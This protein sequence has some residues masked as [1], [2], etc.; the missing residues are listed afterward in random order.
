MQQ[1]EPLAKFFNDELEAQYAA[2]PSH[3]NGGLLMGCALWGETYIERF[4]EFCFPS[5]V[6]PR[7]RAALK[8]RTRLVVFTPA[9]TVAAVCRGLAPTQE[10]GIETVVR[11]IPDAAMEVG[12]SNRYWLL[13][14][15]QSLTLE[16]SKRAGMAYHMLMPDHV[17]SAAYFENLWRMADGGAEII[18][19]CGI[20]ADIAR[21]GPELQTHRL[22]DGTLAIPD[23]TL[24]DI[25]WRALH[26]QMQAFSMMEAKVPEL[27][28]SAFYL[29]WPGK[30]KLVIHCCHANP[31]YL[32]AKVTA[33]APIPPTAFPHMISTIDTKLPALCRPAPVHFAQI[34]DGMT[35]I[36]VS[37]AGKPAVAKFVPP[38]EFSAICWSKANFNDAYL[39]FFRQRCEVPIEPQERYLPDDR[40]RREPKVLHDLLVA[41]K[42]QAALMLHEQ[43]PP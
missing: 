31:A 12:K 2:P 4:A 40:I 27:M 42:A 16:M 19:Q 25:G 32:S 38:D 18:V 21:C 36:E 34:D 30:D 24:G 26:P 20:S 23:R 15:I 6:A 7:N 43:V 5:I 3:G 14:T 37:D 10:W 17:Y 13:G 11:R 41:N 9:P 39:S 35:F 22:E 33:K 28:P 29:L 8:G 1:I